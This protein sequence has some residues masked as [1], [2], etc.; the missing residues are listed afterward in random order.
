[1]LEADPAT[2]PRQQ[3]WHESETMSGL[4]EG[5][6]DA[7]GELAGAAAGK[8]AEMAVEGVSSLL[9]GTTAVAGAVAEGAGPALAGAGQLAGAAAEGAL[10][11]AEEG[12]VEGAIEVVGASFGAG[13]PATVT[14][15]PG[16]VAA[17][18]QTRGRHP[19][20]TTGEAGQGHR[21]TKR[22]R[23]RGHRSQP[24]PPR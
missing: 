1:M 17:A 18:D 15:P 14:P 10:V 13:A 4:F 16:G 8:V 3:R 7:L 22:R 2:A 24:R 5:V 23:R 19:E 6:F 9:E 21:R 11:A 20:S 12:L